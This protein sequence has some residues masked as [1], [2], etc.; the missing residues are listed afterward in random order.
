VAQLERSATKTNLQMPDIKLSKREE[1]ILTCLGYLVMRWNYAERCA[2]QILRGY[3]TG[4]S[5]DDPDH[6]YLSGRI[7]KWIEDEL[8]S[9]IL[10]KWQ[11][12]GRPYI[13]RLIDAF[14]I[15][16]DHRNHLV[17]GI[18]STADTN[19]AL[20]AQAVLLP[21]KPKNRKT[22]LPT[23]ITAAEIRPIADHINDL[24]MFARE[25]MVGFDQR[26][27]HALNADGSPVLDPLPPLIAPLP[28]CR[29]LTT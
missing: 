13:E 6:L 8:R 12:P 20:P 11:G 2:R 7:A 10:P 3:L 15:A 28:P 23:S 17:H 1:E 4:T 5:L 27:D 9:D 25:V 26:G 16:R 18:Y 29:Y 22:Q 14:S 19:G 21:P 24:A